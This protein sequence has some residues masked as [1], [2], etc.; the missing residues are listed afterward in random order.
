[1]YEEKYKLLKGTELPEMRQVRYRGDTSQINLNIV[2]SHWR[3]TGFKQ[4]VDLGRRTS[5]P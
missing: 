4:H 3:R 1:M 5:R 2:D